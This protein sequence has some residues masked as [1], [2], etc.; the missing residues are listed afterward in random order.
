MRLLLLAGTWEARQIASGLAAA[1]IDAVASLAGGT[2][3]P[4]ALELPLRVGG[5]GGRAGFERF[6][7][8]ERIGAVLDA[9]H[10]FAAAMRRRTQAV[11]AEL[12]L[13]HAM[14]LRPG[15]RAGPGDDWHRVAGP[16]EAAALIPG[17]ATVFLATGPARVAEFAAL[18]GRRLWC[19][20]IDPAEAPFPFA[21][22]GWITGRPPFTVAGETELLRRLRVDWLVAKDAG[23][24]GGAAK[25]S[26]A[27]AL[28]LPVALLERPALPPGRVLTSVEAA[29]DWAKDWTKDR[30]GS[31]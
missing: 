2:R 30:A 11:C 14:V 9:L 5:F 25:L 16:G 18:A 12:G 4:A 29:V 8:E 21:G 28:G 7:R 10:P 23:G 17:G 1:G 24:A 15:W 3:A 6:L 26:A 31:A 27:R 22:G 20:R 19:R 13:A